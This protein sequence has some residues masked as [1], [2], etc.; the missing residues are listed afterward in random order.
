[1][2][3]AG[4]LSVELHWMA[5]FRRYSRGAQYTQLSGRRRT[6][7]SFLVDGTHSAALVRERGGRGGRGS[8]TQ[9]T[10][11][12]VRH[13]L[14]TPKFTSRKKK[15]KETTTAPALDGVR[16]IVGHRVQQRDGLVRVDGD[17][18]VPRVR[19][20]VVVGESSVEEAQQRGLVE[21][22]ELG[23]ILCRR[24]RNNIIGTAV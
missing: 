16:V 14:T 22:V 8:D 1:M 19:V 5:A 23:R 2:V 10:G 4:S 15:T 9:R 11:L 18:H 13:H 3:G 24:E 12:C 21:A 20:D 17:E 6:S 7:T